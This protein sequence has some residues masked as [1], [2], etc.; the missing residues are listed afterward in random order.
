MESLVNAKNVL[1]EKYKAPG[2]CLYAC[3]AHTLILVC[4]I[5][6]QHQALKILDETVDEA[7]WQSNLK[8]ISMCTRMHDFCSSLSPS[9]L[10]YRRRW[11]RL[12]CSVPAKRTLCAVSSLSSKACSRERERQRER[13]R[14]IYIY[15]Y[16]E[17][18][19]DRERERERTKSTHKSQYKERQGE[20]K[21]KTERCRERERERD[22][23][24]RIHS[25]HML[26]A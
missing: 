17:R 21:K 1:E 23:E 4:I 14:E 6:W 12:S 13:E 5:K 15:I 10:L 20:N 11:Q 2:I 26:G 25:I 18:E 7:E 22:R 3:S 9:A 8:A 24:I 16:I 19:R